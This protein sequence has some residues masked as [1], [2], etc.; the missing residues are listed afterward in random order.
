MDLYFKIRNMLFYS[1]NYG[2]AGE[3]EKKPLEFIRNSLTAHE[4]QKFISNRQV[5]LYS[6]NSLH[7]FHFL[8]ENSFIRYSHTNVWLLRR[9]LNGG[10]SSIPFIFIWAGVFF[11]QKW[12]LYRDNERENFS[13]L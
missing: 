5:R 13:S 10:C 12:I 1:P 2:N 8:C 11:C 3:I 6:Y 9:Q 4:K 7:E